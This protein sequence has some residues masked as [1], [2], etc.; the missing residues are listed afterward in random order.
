MGNPFVH[1]ELM[2]N[3]LPKAKEFYTS[4]F[5]W[6][7]HED[8]ALNYTLIAVGDGT[9]GGMMTNPVPNTPSH[10]M[11]YVQVDDIHASSQKAKSLGG[12]VVHGPMEVTGHGWVCV[13]I[14]PTGAAFGMWQP[15]TG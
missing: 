13:I 9:G 11:P 7:L 5:D 8:P 4:L 6:Q 12:S 14:D 3:D 15:K 2:A 1:C 10:W